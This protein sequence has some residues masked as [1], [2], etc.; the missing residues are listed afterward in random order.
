MKPVRSC[1]KMH[2]QSV[3]VINLK[4]FGRIEYKNIDLYCFSAIIS[5]FLY[6]LVPKCDVHFKSTASNPIEY[7]YGPRS[8]AIGDFNN[9]TWLDMVV[10][11]TVV[12]N[13]AV[14]LS[15]RNDTFSDPIKYA[16]GLYSSPCMVAVGH[17]N[18]DSHLDIVVA[19]FGTNNVG[20]FLGFN[21]GSF[22]SQIEVSTAASRPFALCLADFDGDTILDIATANYGRH[23]ITI[24]YGYGNGSFFNSITYWTGYD[25]HSFSLIAGDFDN[26]NHL[27][28]AIANYGT[29]NIGI[30]FGNDNRSFIDQVIF[31]TGLGSHPSS[32][33]VGYFN[34]D[35][36]LDIAVAL[37]GTNNTHPHPRLRY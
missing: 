10:A 36:F 15:N 8:V 34:N 21:N 31:S 13:I 14:Y 30:L 12:N 4:T 11:N 35:N 19:N 6:Y 28:V 9:D 33:A 20:I 24:F 26:D 16:T 29:D 27:D 17:V 5:L 3:L 25:S 22:A 23:S 1:K 32:L 37:S 18:N 7:N 2:D